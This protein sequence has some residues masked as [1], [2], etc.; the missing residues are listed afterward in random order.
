MFTVEE[1]DRLR[2]ALIARARADDR[3]TGAA[4]TGSGAL[5]A[6]DA[7]SDIDLAFGLRA[8]VD[9]GRTMADWTTLM[10]REHGA[11]DHTELTFGSTVFRVFLL[12]STLQVDLA[13]APAAEFGAIAPTFRL[14]FGTA[15]Q[16]PPQPEPDAGRLVGMGWLYALHARSSIARGRVWQAEYMISG[17]RDYVLALACLRHGLPATQG[18]GVDSLPP[19]VSSAVA[20][21][22]VRSLDL[23]E[24]ARAF[25]AATDA[26]LGEVERVDAGLARR[27]AGPLRELSRAGARPRP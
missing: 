24:L 23:D 12:G 3:I 26:L 15:V 5:D 19:E 6:T 20:G 13:F 2:D 18:R 7:W 9:L 25:R 11:V 17:L 27:L 1:R 22:L 16:R 4:V 10:Y 14:V 8:D 21:A